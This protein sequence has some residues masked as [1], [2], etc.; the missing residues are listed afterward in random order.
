MH[1]GIFVRACVLRQ[2]CQILTM[3]EGASMTLVGLLPP[4]S[5]NG[6]M[7]VDGGYCKSQGYNASRNI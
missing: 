6:E 7:L 3:Y 5:D 4:L 1:G 2:Y